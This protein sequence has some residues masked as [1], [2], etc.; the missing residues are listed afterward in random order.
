MPEKTP[1]HL[2]IFSQ[3]YVSPDLFFYFSPEQA[4]SF[5]LNS[6]SASYADIF[7]QNNIFH[8]YSLYHE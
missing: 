7:L 1:K 6:S 2:L 3:V 5:S 8:T 4:L